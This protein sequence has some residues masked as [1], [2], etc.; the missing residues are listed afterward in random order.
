M[1]YVVL[2][3]EDNIFLEARMPESSFSIFLWTTV[4]TGTEKK[5]KYTKESCQS[6]H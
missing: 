4:L 3:L 1:L 2:E 5:I 6:E